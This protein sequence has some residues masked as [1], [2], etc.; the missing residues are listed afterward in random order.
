MH[1]PAGTRWESTTAD[2]APGAR[3]ENQPMFS[4]D[5]HAEKDGGM[6]PLQRSTPHAIPRAESQ[7][8][9]GPDGATVGAD[10]TLFRYFSRTKSGRMPRRCCSRGESGLMMIWCPPAE[11]GICS[12][13]LPCD[14]PAVYWPKCPTRT[15]TGNVRPVLMLPASGRPLPS[16]GLPDRCS[17]ER[18]STRR[19]T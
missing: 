14:A 11:A 18:G 16:R 4:P 6:S 15:G 1:S 3:V 13:L 17:H 7:G 10:L 8:L 12:T 19:S 2:R 5:G 9:N